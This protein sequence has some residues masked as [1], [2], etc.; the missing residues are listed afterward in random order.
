MK[1]NAAP[2]IEVTI[3]KVS[4]II[5]VIVCVLEYKIANYQDSVLLIFGSTCF[6][7][8]YGRVTS[9]LSLFVL[10]VH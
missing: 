10:P 6:P 5:C 8:I 4:F 9:N 1:L 3:K 2:G 7:Y